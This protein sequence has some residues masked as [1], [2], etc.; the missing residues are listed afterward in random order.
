MTVFPLGVL[1]GAAPL[2][3]QV[4]CTHVSGEGHKVSDNLL[5]AYGSG[6][7]YPSI[8]KLGRPFAVGRD[9]TQGRQFWGHRKTGDPAKG[10]RGMGVNDR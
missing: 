8:A 1:Q 9:S 3:K 5:L 7:D 2:D 10:K 4:G 6:G